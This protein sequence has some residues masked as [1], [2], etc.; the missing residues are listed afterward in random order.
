[1]LDAMNRLQSEWRRL[2]LPREA[3]SAA[4]AHANLIDSAGAVRALVLELSRP[5]DWDLLG[6]V[7][8]GVQTDLELPAPAIAVSGSDGFQLWFSL[9]DAVSLAL[10]QRFLES[11]CCRYLPEVAPG[12][13]RL[14]P[15]AATASQPA[16]HAQNVPAL[17]P[18]TGYWSAYIAA[19][20]APIFAETPWL[21]GAPGA[22]GQGGVLSSLASISRQ[23]FDAA[24]QRL[25]VTAESIPASVPAHADPPPVAVTEASAADPDPRR[26]LQ[27]VMNDDSVAL[28]LRI[29]A[30]KALLPYWHRATGGERAA[31]GDSEV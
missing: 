13:L 31:I 30:A 9:T 7:W 29:E 28:E 24:L 2:Y 21:D 6:A 8:R 15:Q 26:F 16:V 1:M 25:G 3:S 18:R 12:R 10:A 11:L 22:D 4:A 20:L 14:L 5:A 17:H 27:Q 23:Q 19:D